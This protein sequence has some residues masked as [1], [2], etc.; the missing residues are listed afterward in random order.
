MAT[1]HMSRSCLDV[2][3]ALKHNS[4][5]SPWPYGLLG[6]EKFILPSKKPAADAGTSNIFV[7]QATDACDL[8]TIVETW[9]SAGEMKESTGELANPFEI[10]TVYSPGAIFAGSHHFAD[11]WLVASGSDVKVV[12]A[13]SW[14]VLFFGHSIMLVVVSARCETDSAAS[15]P[16]AAAS[17][18]ASLQALR[19]VARCI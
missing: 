18:A 5:S 1:K 2:T 3:A 14:V 6:S 4:Q 9:G 7:G 11:H 17:C 13:R 10:V 16:K 8:T 12:Q 19:C 15:T